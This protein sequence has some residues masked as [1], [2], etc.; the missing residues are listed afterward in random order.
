MGYLAPYGG[1]TPLPKMEI[2]KMGNFKK[3][4]GSTPIVY[5]I[6]GSIWVECTLPNMEITKK[7]KLPKKEILKDVSTLVVYEIPGP[8][9]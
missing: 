6:P 3:I 1:G 2:T 9:W 5:G 8:I 4:D 7:R